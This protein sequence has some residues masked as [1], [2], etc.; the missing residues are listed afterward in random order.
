MVTV[1]T[2]R[3]AR[4]IDQAA[5]QISKL[6]A[7]VRNLTRVDQA[8][9]AGPVDLSAGLMETLDVIRLKAQSKSVSVSLQL[10]SDLPPVHGF[11]GE[12]GQIWANLIGNA[13]DAVPESGRIDVVARRDQRS[14]TVS[15]VDDGPGIPANIRERNLAASNRAQGESTSIANTSASDRTSRTFFSFAPVSHKRAASAIRK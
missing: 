1:S 2:R 7:A 4:E 11:G 13:I 5:T 10:D 15:I 9:A 12:L 8:A 14:V 6:V 3:L